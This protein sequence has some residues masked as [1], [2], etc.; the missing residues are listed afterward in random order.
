M[1]FSIGVVFAIGALVFWG[2][3]DFLIQRTTRHIGDWET[4]FLISVF[5]A[6]ILTPFVYHDLPGYFSTL[7]AQVT[8]A[9]VS[10]IIFVGA[11]INFEALKKGKIAAIEPMLSLEVPVVAVLSLVVINEALSL[12]EILFVVVLIAGL[13]MVS[14][15][16]HHLSRKVWLEKGVLL[17]VIAAFLLGLADFLVGFGSRI[18][19][20]LVV[21]WF[22]S[23]TLTVYTL[24]Y[25]SFRGGVRNAVRDAA[26]IPRLIVSMCIFDNFAWIAYAFAAIFIPI[27][28]AV[29]I[30]EN[31]IALAALLGLFITGE[32][33]MPHQKIG[34]V[35]ALSSAVVLSLLA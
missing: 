29:A 6:V 7:Q 27:T 9:V 26:K 24:V 19:N 3:G 14:L 31:Y 8:L 5:G 16:Q 23:L 34:L 11:L 18:T 33:L 15:K 17:A 20:P 10:L 21:N 2:I 12:M 28:I 1:N 22:I 35:M 32:K 25:I 13:S 30:S 4:L